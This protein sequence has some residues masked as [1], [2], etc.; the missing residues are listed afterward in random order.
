MR[1]RGLKRE[2]AIATPRGHLRSATQYPLTCLVL[3][4]C[5]LVAAFACPSLA[6]D[7]PSDLPAAPP[8]SEPPVAAPPPE[9]PGAAPPSVAPPTE[10][11][12]PAPAEPPAP[13]PAPPATVPA[14][15]NAAFAPLP[16]EPRTKP[17]PPSHPAAVSAPPSA[18]PEPKAAPLAED[19][20]HPSAASETVHHQ[21]EP[22]KDEDGDGVFGPFRIGVLVGGGLPEIL[23]LGGQIKL[24]RF[25]GAGINIGLIPTVKISYYG[26]AKLSY[27]EYDAYGR[28]YPFGGSFF[29][30][31]GV[32]YATIK[33][34]VNGKLS[35]D[36]AQ[37]MYPGFGIP[38]PILVDSQ[39]SVR[40]LVL[41][42]Q[43]GF[44]K[45]FG[46]GFTIG[47]DVGA[48][49]PIA[50][51]KVDFATNTPNLQEPAKSYVQSTYVKPNDDKVRSTLDTI[52]R[53]PLPTFNL[54]IG[55]FL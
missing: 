53:T 42:P 43:V 22:E 24:T 46:S 23:S 34:T 41:T 16:D 13:A 2:F 38:N 14:T 52:G 3:S 25:I 37:T 7:A 27:Q 45:I 30:G 26:D 21:E 10:T 51:S 17:K 19:N 49:L 4:S 1:V 48:Q 28:L 18:Q 32:G 12:P 20:A 11:L 6:Q 9:P 31:A 39:G 36:A 33:G 5:L 44:M 54:K 35:T 40:T 29:V 8:S 55:W 15:G 50:P 47:I